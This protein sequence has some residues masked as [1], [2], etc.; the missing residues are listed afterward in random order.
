MARTGGGTVRELV[1]DN[2]APHGRLLGRRGTSPHR[3]RLL[4]GALKEKGEGG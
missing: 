4:R 2:E 3:P 1:A